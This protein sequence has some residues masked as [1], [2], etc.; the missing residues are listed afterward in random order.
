MVPKRVFSFR[1]DRPH[2]SS[3]NSLFSCQSRLWIRSRRGIW[4]RSSSFSAHQ[5]KWRRYKIQI[6]APMR[7]LLNFSCLMPQLQHLIDF[8]CQMGKRQRVWVF[9]DPDHF[10]LQGEWRSRWSILGT[11]FVAIQPS[12][13]EK[14]ALWRRH[15]S[16]PPWPGLKLCWC[17]SSL[18]LVSTF[19]LS[20]LPPKL[21]MFMLLPP[22][23]SNH[24]FLEIRANHWFRDVW[25]RQMVSPPF[26]YHKHTKH[27]KMDPRKSAH[28]QTTNRR[29]GSFRFLES[30]ALI[31]PYS[32]DRSKAR[33]SE[34]R[35]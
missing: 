30:C 3:K 31:L 34:L 14:Q 9:N 13:S 8:F 1:F 10:G 23:S 2:R 4:I 35:S 22:T 27:P 7:L 26:P 17:K 5:T 15:T 32:F 25:M 24:W 20:E 19:M 28:S 6:P 16:Y 33:L 29:L 18:V 11:S 12:A 21:D